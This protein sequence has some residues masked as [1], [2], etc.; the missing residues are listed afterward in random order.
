MSLDEE[1]IE[2]EIYDKPWGF[3]KTTFLNPYSRAKIIKINPLGELS[4]QEHSRRE[5][6]WVIIKG[7]G[8]L[9][10]GDSK[11]VMQAGDYIFIPKQCKHKITNISSTEPLMISEIQLG[12]YFG[13]DDIIRYDDKYGRV[14]NNSVTV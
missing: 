14:S 1:M 12:E 8:E 4:L 11:K 6:H 2:H 10:I 9:I 7:T 13:E 5:E 3:F